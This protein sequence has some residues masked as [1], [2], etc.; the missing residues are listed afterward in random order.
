[1]LHTILNEKFTLP[2]FGHVQSLSRVESGNEHASIYQVDYRYNI[3]V[4]RPAYIV[5]WKKVYPV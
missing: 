1:M 5:E 3:Y 2:Q 4:Y